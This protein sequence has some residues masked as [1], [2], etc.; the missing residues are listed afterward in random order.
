MQEVL[1]YVPQKEKRDLSASQNTQISLEQHNEPEPEPSSSK[2]PTA[3][4]TC[5]KPGP[6]KQL[7]EFR[8]MYK[9]P[10]YKRRRILLQNKQEITVSFRKRHKVV[11]NDF[12]YF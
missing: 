1:N 4:E 11:T 5:I 9:Q 8:G 2:Y 3:A 7:S 6:S 10:E 12:W